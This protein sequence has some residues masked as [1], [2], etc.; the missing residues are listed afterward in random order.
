MFLK[1]PLLKYKIWG[2]AAIA[3]C[4][5]VVVPTKSPVAERQIFWLEKYKKQK[6][7]GV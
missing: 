2:W 7:I 3:G 1:L 6:Y 5:K 4:H